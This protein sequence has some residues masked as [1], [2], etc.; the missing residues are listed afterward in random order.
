MVWFSV[1]I[2]YLAVFLAAVASIIIGGL[3]YSPVLFGNAWMRAG[4]MTKDMMEGAKKKGMAWRY[5]LA[6]IGSLLVAYV[7]SHFIDYAQAVSFTD[8]MLAG[9]W[10]WLGFII[11]VLLGSVLWECKTWTYYMINVLYQL[12][13][14]LIIGGI[15][16]SWA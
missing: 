9:F 13:N 11:P 12:V 3:W 6:F 14:L 15:L 4:N 1:D 2:N 16:A 10:V 8:G 7:L 5:I